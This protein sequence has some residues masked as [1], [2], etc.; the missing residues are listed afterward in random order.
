MRFLKNNFLIAIIVL[1]AT[2]ASCSFSTIDPGDK[3]KEELLL[4]LITHV[5]KR[6]HFAPADLTDEFSKEVFE[7]FITDLDPG[8]RYFLESDIEEFKAYETQIDDE[9]QNGS[10]EFFQLVYK[11]YL[12]RQDE[13]EAIFKEIV[14]KPFDFSVKEEI[15]I[16]FE[17]I[18]YSADAAAHKEHW[19][20][21]LK[22]QVLNSVYDKM[23][24][25]KEKTEVEKKSIEQLERTARKEV[26]KNMVE[27]FDIRE[28]S[29]RLDYFSAYVNA[30][31]AYFDPHTNYFPP[32]NKDRFDTAMRGSLQGIGARLQK[33]MDYISVVELISGGPAWKSQKIEVGDQILKVRQ[34]NDTVATSIVGMRI[35]NAVD[36]IKGPKGTKVILTLKKVDGSIKDLQLTRDVVELEDTYAKAIMTENDGV[37]YGIID[38]PKFY[39]DMENPEGRA[40]GDDVAAEIERLKEEGMDGLVIDLR[41]NGGGSLREVVE[42]MGLFIDNGPVVQVALKNR[43]TQTLQDDDNGSVLWDGPLVVLVNEF[44]ASASEILAAALQDYERAV[45]LGSKQTFGKGTVQVIDDLNR[46]V[47]NSEHGDLGAV[48]FTTQKFY[49]VNGS[50][51]QLEGVKSDVVLPSRYSYMELG[52]KDEDFPLPYDEIKPADYDKYQGYLNLADAITASQKRVAANETFDLIDQNAKWLKAQQEENSVSLNYDQYVA[53]IYELEAQTEKFDQLDEYK[54]DLKFNLL[55]NDLIKTQNDTVLKDKRERWIKSLSK[56][57]Y[58]EEAVNVLNDLKL[59]D[60]RGGYTI[61]N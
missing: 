20:K 2:T 25:Q 26:K 54:N 16:D 23:Q 50:S 7:N 3:E 41:N 31:L 58:L 49:R 46:W 8:K 15:L 28:D 5:L 9:I 55:R 4:S 44:S 47:R 51:T 29:E 12:K 17:K 30:I 52:E 36:L 48:K 21:I 11:R 60:I 59:R 10:I 56:D 24:E 22:S 45:I 1:L 34:E 33:K 19:R 35:S 32:Q 43:A 57:V 14:E 42:M 37:R 38:L 39:F 53:R 18:P 61:K 13:A 27:S 40:A 6:N